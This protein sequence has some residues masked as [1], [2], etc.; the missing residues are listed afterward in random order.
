MAAFPGPTP[1]GLR[2]S[3]TAG[4]HLPSAF[5]SSGDRML[6]S[7]DFLISW[8][9]IFPGKQKTDRTAHPVQSDEHRLR[10]PALSQ[11]LQALYFGK[12]PGLLFSL[13]R[14]CDL[15]MWVH[16]RQITQYI[17]GKQ[18]TQREQTGERKPEHS[19]S[20][21]K[22]NNISIR[23]AWVTWSVKHLTLGFSLGHDLAVHRIKPRV[24]IFSFPLSF[25]LSK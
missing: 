3:Q 7:W 23:G 22:L 17:Q 24:G 15:S 2:E 16:T 11:S 13:T 10:A 21:I 9:L 20:L 1:A 14:A 5:I 19:R 18:T 8:N 4:K 25:S 12:I 6:V